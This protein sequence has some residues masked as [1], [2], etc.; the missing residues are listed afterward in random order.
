MRDLD[1]KVNKFIQERSV[2]SAKKARG[3][4]PM[5]KSMLSP[6]T[7]AFS[8]AGQSATKV[9]KNVNNRTFTMTVTFSPQ[10]NPRFHNTKSKDISI[11]H[12][13]NKQKAVTMKPF[14]HAKSPKRNPITQDGQEPCYEF[15]A[16]FKATPLTGKMTIFDDEVPTKKKG[17]GDYKEW[18]SRPR[19]YSPPVPCIKTHYGRA[20][21]ED[22]SPDS[23]RRI[24]KGPTKSLKN[25][26]NPIVEGDL[27]SLIARRV[28]KGA[29]NKGPSDE[30]Q[31]LNDRKQ[32]MSTDIGYSPKGRVFRD[33]SLVGFAHPIEETAP[34]KGRRYASPQFR[35]QPEMHGLLQYSYSGSFRQENVSPKCT[36]SSFYDI[37]K[38]LNTSHMF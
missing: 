37:V 19:E 22:M 10:V 33:T 27:D 8:T 11:Y 18:V 23:P 25:L 17:E 21:R 28:R 32:L 5:M 3:I 1:R 29:L 35:K 36:S 9:V 38:G 16:P 2:Q 4:S 15:K 6:S 7:A 26:L 13:G 14:D 30:T 20:L 24:R 12:E 34:V 31:K